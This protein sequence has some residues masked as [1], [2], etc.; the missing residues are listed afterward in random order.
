MLEEFLSQNEGKTLEFKEN[1][2]NLKGIIKSIVAFANTAG[3]VILIGIK[4]HSKE[5]IGLEDSLLEEEKIANAVADS[6]SPLMIA[7]IEI[8]SYRNKELLVIR[9]PHVAGP[10]YLKKE[11]EEQGIYIRLGSTNRKADP[12][13]IKTLRLFASNISFDELPSKGTIDEAYLKETFQR[14]NKSPTKKQCEMLGIYSDHFGEIRPS[15]GGILLFN[16]K[17]TEILPDSVIRCA[18]FKGSTK[19]KILNHIDVMVPLPSAIEEVIAFI[20]KHSTREAVIGKIRRIDVPQ[21]PSEALRELVI[22]S[23]VH[24]DY[25]MKGSQIQVALFSDRLEI[26]NPGGLPFGQ[27]IE[28]A[29]SGYSRLRNHV[30]GRVFRELKYIEQ[31]GSGLQRIRAICEKLGLKPP[32]FEER[33]N[34]FRAILYSTKEGHAKYSRNEQVLINYLIKHS[35]IQTSEAAKL[36]KLS[37]RATRTR[38]SKMLKEGLIIR[39]STSPKDP[40]A[41]YILKKN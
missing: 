14:V 3:G 30:I 36:W 12:E 13:T 34:H 29:L 25:S 21:Y 10:Y 5:I 8:A 18:Y 11:G 20:E 41:V 40:H 15:I 23:L 19:E 22:N 4:D 35:T 1:T 9:I 17:R 31:W 38:L 24:A 26:T 32:K 28:K 37:D 6:I 7:S 33:D 16:I 27:T 39:I 2:N